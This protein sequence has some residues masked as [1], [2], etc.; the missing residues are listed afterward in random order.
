MANDKSAPVP[1]AYPDSVT[2][3]QVYSFYGDEGQYFRW[4]AG[5]TVTE[6]SEIKVLVDRKA[7]LV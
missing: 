2:L 1:N 4:A 3:A 7:P 6:A 5:L